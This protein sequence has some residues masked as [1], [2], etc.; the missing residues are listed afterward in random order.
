MKKYLTAFMLLLQIGAFADWLPASQPIP[1]GTSTGIN[2]TD[3][4][5]TYDAA[6]QTVV[7]AWSNLSDSAAYYAVY[8]GST[9]ITPGTPIPLGASGGVDHDVT[10]TYD[11]AT[12]TV[13]AA[14]GSNFIPYYAVFDGTSWTTPGTIIPLGTSTGVFVRNNVNVTYDP[15]NQTVIA[16][17]GDTVTTLP[18]YAV[19]D[20]SSWTTPGTQIPSGLSS[21]VLRDVTVIY[22]A[23][24]QTIIAAWADG[25]IQLP[26]YAVF[27]GSSWTTTGTRIPRGGSTGA[28]D[29]VNLVYDAVNQ[30]V[31]AAWGDASTRAPYYAV[32]NGSSWIAAELISPIPN[33]G[34]FVNRNISMAFD[35]SSQIVI[36]AWS[37]S[38]D[39]LPY[40][41]IFTGTSWTT[42]APVPVAPSLGAGT[43]VILVFDP[44][45][46]QTVATWSDLTAT[47]QGFFNI[48]VGEPVVVQ[49][50]PATLTVNGCRLTFASQQVW[51]NQLIWTPS[52]SL[53]V[54][55]YNI[56]RN[57]A[58]IAT[59]SADT[60]LYNDPVN[61]QG[62]D[63]YGV[64]SVSS[65][66][67]ESVPITVT[68]TS[69]GSCPR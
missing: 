27:D 55:A 4:Y 68:V 57:G 69:N 41:S 31:I 17:W 30:T 65:T 18:Y 21:G 64:T 3:V 54:V 59:V 13:I 38:A 47:P 33:V 1:M 11:A 44:A 19:F 24:N 20:G 14:W 32:F 42:I 51:I 48:F 37:S 28:F 66:G 29:D 26:Y 56:Y 25:V 50:P 15:A 67:A 34:A 9:W 22:D 43:N 46:A 52:L 40:Y 53:D 45:A 2:F 62:V 35:S 39:A 5:T 23:A 58:L 36:A 8:D 6:N 61:T 7:A 10:L 16:A 12:Q 49:E 63:V 60:F